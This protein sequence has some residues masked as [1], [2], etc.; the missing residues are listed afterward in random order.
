[1]QLFAQA[2][3]AVCIN[4]PFG[5]DPVS[6][7]NED[8]PLFWQ[9][10]VERHFSP[11]SSFYQ[12]SCVAQ[13]ERETKNKKCEKKIVK[14]VYL[15]EGAIIT[16]K[17]IWH[18]LF[19]SFP[20]VAVAVPWENLCVGERKRERESKCRQLSR[21]DSVGREQAAEKRIGDLWERVSAVM[22]ERASASSASSS[23]LSKMCA[24]SWTQ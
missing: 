18:I 15:K 10:I 2:F 22:A 14:K 13:H 21:R 9:L 12:G 24:D 1:M 8:C 5:V 19:L 16:L 11:W 7:S 20:V 17:M 3:W 23:S 4:S 6:P